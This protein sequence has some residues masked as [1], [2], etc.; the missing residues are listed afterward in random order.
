MP[1]WKG[2]GQDGVQGYWF[3]SIKAK[4]LILATL[5]T[6]ALQSVNAP[7]WLTIGRTVL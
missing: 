5:F 1:N 6:E 4:R 7:K 3:K 2:S